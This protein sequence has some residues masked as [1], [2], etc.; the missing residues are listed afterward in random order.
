MEEDR[1][2]NDGKSFLNLSSSTGGGRMWSFRMKS[3]C[4]TLDTR[5]VVHAIRVGN[6][7]R[8]PCLGRSVGGIGRRVVGRQVGGQVGEGVDSVRSSGR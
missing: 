6:D 5:T 2:G 8:A 1:I 7:G 3:G 4:S